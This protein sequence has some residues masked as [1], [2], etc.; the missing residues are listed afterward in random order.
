MI[1]YDLRRVACWASDR[2][3]GVDLHA[4]LAV[5]Y[6]LRGQMRAAMTLHDYTGSNVWA[7]LVIDLPSREFMRAVLDMLFQR[8]GVRR[9]TMAVRDD[10]L[11]CLRL[12][13]HIGAELESTMPHGHMAGDVFIYVLWRNTGVHR[14]HAALQ[15]A[16]HG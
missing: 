11:R 13:R 3:G 7:H 12:M 14:G 10:N 8:L 16:H 6:L 9:V 4:D 15:G 2:F 1:T 5:G